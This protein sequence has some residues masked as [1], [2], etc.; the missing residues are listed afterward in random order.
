MAGYRVFF[1][2]PNVGLLSSKGGIEGALR[3]YLARRIAVTVAL[4]EESAQILRTNGVDVT[5]IMLAD[6]GVEVTGDMI[7]RRSCPNDHEFLF[8]SRLVPHK[9]CDDLLRAFIYAGLSDS[10]A[11][12]RVL[13][14]GPMRR[15]LENLAAELAI[16]DKVI[17]EGNVEDVPRFMARAGCLVVCSEKEGMSNVV[18]EAMSIGLPVIST[19]VGGVTRALGEFGS[20]FT[21]SPGDV[22]YLAYLMSQFVKNPSFSNGYGQYL[23]ERCTKRFEISRVAETYIQKYSESGCTGI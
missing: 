23:F 11:I 9:R 5:R 2:L 7:A 8:V 20:R 14:D 3:R 18:L 1:K 12:V 13:G 19:K 6:N 15:D 22:R 16:S 10:N 17:F 21:Y 4:E